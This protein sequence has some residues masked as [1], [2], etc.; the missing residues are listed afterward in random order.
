[1]T[2][3]LS[4]VLGVALAC[5]FINGAQAHGMGGELFLVMVLGALLIPV[6]LGAVLGFL[7]GLVVYHKPWAGIG[8]GAG[9][10]AGACVAVAVGYLTYLLIGSF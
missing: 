7:V 1:M 6:L 8:V 4:P 10:A 5:L 2:R 3:F 9:S